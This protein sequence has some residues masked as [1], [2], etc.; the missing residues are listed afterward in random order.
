MDF[1]DFIVWVKGGQVLEFRHKAKSVHE[2][3]NVQDELILDYYGSQCVQRSEIRVV[4]LD[5]RP[6]FEE[7]WKVF[8]CSPFGYSRELWKFINSLSE[9]ER[10]RVREDYYRVPREA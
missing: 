5:P 7:Y 1:T 9:E 8:E 3:W 4:Q 2:F 6:Y 10:E